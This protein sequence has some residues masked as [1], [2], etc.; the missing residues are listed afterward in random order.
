MRYIKNY[1]MREWQNFDTD[2]VISVCHECDFETGDKEKT[3]DHFDATTHGFT[4]ETRNMQEIMCKKYNISLT[5]FQTKEEIETQRKKLSKERKIQI[6]KQ[7][8]YIMGVIAVGILKMIDTFSSKPTPK[9]RRK[10]KR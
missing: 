8:Y 9:K 5:D 4:W 2:I 1:S 6:L 7:S 3:Y 10:R